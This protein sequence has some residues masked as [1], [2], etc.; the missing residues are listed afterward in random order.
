MATSRIA[1]EIAG[2]EAQA[3]PAAAP[4]APRGRRILLVDDHPVNRR[5]VSVMLAP[6]GWVIVEA[7]HGQAALDRLETEPFDLVL[8][9]VNM[10]VMGGLEAARRI[11]ARPAWADLPI[12][13]LTAD[14]MD[15]QIRACR[16]AGMD[17]FVVKPVDMAALVAAVTRAGS[18]AP[19]EGLKA[20]FAAGA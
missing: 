20:R 16:E 4:L 3:E 7:E 17:D 5:V 6:F 11:R 18:G 1:G 19:V 14:V 10:P 15:D 12:I 2:P 13:A 8:M 9:D